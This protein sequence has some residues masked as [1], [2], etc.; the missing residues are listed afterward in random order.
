MI[1]E[2]THDYF[3]TIAF[4]ILY[5]DVLDKVWAFI[6]SHTER[7]ELFVRLGQ[8]I[9]EGV[10]Q[11]TNGKMARLVNVLQGFDDT[12]E[13][14]PPREAFHDK[15]ASLMKLPKEERVD[16]AEK[17]FLE[18]AIPVKEQSVWIAPLLLED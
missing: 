3:E 15:I 7:D 2:L 8:E 10:G 6:R 1:T 12:L 13:V 9:A 17:L 14:D 18:F 5:G 11:C 4:S 16:A